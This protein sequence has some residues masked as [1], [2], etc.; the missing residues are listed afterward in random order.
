M[1][2]NG[3]LTGKIF[4]NRYELGERIGVGGM[5]EVYMAQDLV[6]GRIVAVK[7][8][9]PQYAAD[10]DFTRRFRQEAA[11]A[12]NLQ[13]PY[14]VN[15]YD[16]GHSDDNYF[17]VMEYI[18]GSDLK[19][20]IK[21][22]GAI[23]ERKVAEIAGQVCQ[24]LSAAHQ[25]D[26]IHRDIKPQNIMIQPD[27]NVKVMDFGIARA[28]NSTA[29]KTETVL[30]TAHYTSPE[31][32]QGKE[33]TAASDIYSL[34]VVMYEA[35][36]GQLPF[37]GPDAVSVALMQIQ[38][39]PANPRDVNPKISPEFEAIILTAM[40]KDPNARF[41]TVND[42]RR[43]LTDFL[44]G[45]PIN[46]AALAG[47]AV[48]GGAAGY[49]A[50]AAMGASVADAAPTE[51]INMQDGFTS[52]RTSVIQPAGGMG[53]A[54]AVGP[55]STGGMGAGS[56]QV[57]PVS[58]VGGTQAYGG[59]SPMGSGARNY[60]TGNGDFNDEKP[61]RGKKIAIAVIAVIAV[62]AIAVG[63]ALANGGEKVE[64]PNVVGMTSEEA[65]T[66]IEK[67]GFKLGKVENVNDDSVEA[68]TVTKQDPTGGSQAKKGSDINLVVSQGSEKLEVPDVRGM[69]EAQAKKALVTAGFTLGKTTEEYSD[70]VEEGQ[71]ISQD[72]AGG[73]EA[74]KGTAVNIVKSKGADTVSVPDLRGLSVSEAQSK[75]QKEGFNF[76]QSGSEYSDS[77]DEGCIISQNPSGGNKA[78]KGATISCV[79][80]KGPNNNVEVPNVVGSS[81]SYAKSAITNAGLKVN[82][83]QNYSSSVAKGNVISQSPSSGT[84]KKGDTVTI[85][86][87]LG[88]KPSDESSSDSS[89]STPS[90]NAATNST[91]VVQ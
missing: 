66:S 57:M 71:V 83:T 21:E 38:Q 14:I 56:T 16:W 13:S 80:S 10:P 75:A 79:V 39:Q 8:M 43:A 6:L 73:S 45:R 58:G 88:A 85:E 90:T 78:E 2:G 22:R 19:T 20:A 53:A 11:S 18:R 67:A 3:P 59:V 54:G 31:Q 17:I 64:V 46:L 65:I 26:I 27:G 23:N 40:Q 24:A 32:A 48:I 9:L 84:A 77:V 25:Q 82:V 70:S 12:A 74:N 62:I 60:Q 1:A 87:S 76:S 69:T 35:A 42:M 5:A 51:A 15:V 89:S 55:G 47:G 49:A 61:G 4:N 91:R 34:G 68:G 50:G 52:A 28:K 37:D 44:A 72:P 41:A 86:V 29:E 7:T 33:L 30:G 81:E 36:T 63:F